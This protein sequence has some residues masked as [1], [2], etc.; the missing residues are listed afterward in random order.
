MSVT[1]VEVRARL[2]A[3]EPNYG[4][5]AAALGEDMLPHLEAL[6]QGPDGYLAAKA[7]ALA[8]RVG[9][10]GVAPIL[11]RAARHA[12]PVVRAQVAGSSRRVPPEVAAEILALL[13][14][15]EDS[16]IRKTSLRSVRVRF[17]NGEMPLALRNR[18]AALAA[19]TRRRLCVT[20]RE[21]SSSPINCSTSWASRASVACGTP[22]AVRT[23]GS[24]SRRS[25][26]RPATL[27]FST[28]GCAGATESCTC[29]RSTDSAACRTRSAA[30]ARGAALAL[31][32]A[33]R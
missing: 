7:I 29:A 20:W 26:V 13:V 28:V 21:R 32:P 17:E 25:R 22:F 2:D 10:R 18:I 3:E 5:A 9:G 24:D 6:A 33:A 11:R 19:W 14:S 31:S 30:R 15:D 23:S 27:Q 4:A 16:G 12:L 8:A 1:M